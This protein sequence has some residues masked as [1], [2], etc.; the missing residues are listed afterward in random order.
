MNSIQY[1]REFKDRPRMI[2]THL[3]YYLLPKEIRNNDKKPKVTKFMHDHL[4]INKNLL[5]FFRF[6]TLFVT[7]KMH[8]HR[9][10]IIT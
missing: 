3:P 7:Q 10:I 5:F 9:T 1:I 4:H 8:A 2:K 6:C